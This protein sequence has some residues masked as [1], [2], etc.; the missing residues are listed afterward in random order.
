MVYRCDVH[1]HVSRGELA[2]VCGDGGEMILFII[3]FM[4]LIIC[5]V[6]FMTICL[7]EVFKDDT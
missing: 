6:G 2:V 3:E 7:I 5:F 1:Y 4:A